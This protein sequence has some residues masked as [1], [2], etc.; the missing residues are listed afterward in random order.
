MYNIIIL[1]SKS[2]TRATLGMLGSIQ[3]MTC[4][5][6]TVITL[7]FSAS[8][9][10]KRKRRKKENPTNPSKNEPDDIFKNSPPHPCHMDG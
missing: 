4:S 6:P 3:L 7:L 9:G 10:N 1:P 8:M 2:Q 5:F